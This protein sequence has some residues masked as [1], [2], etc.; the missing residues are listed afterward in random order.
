M[1]ISLNTG[2]RN[3]TLG[4]QET[5]WETRLRTTETSG[6]GFPRLALPP[7]TAEASL[8][9]VVYMRDASGQT[10]MYVDGVEMGRTTIGGTLTNWD[11][12]YR[13]GLANELNQARPW[14]GELHLVA[15]YDRALSSA[16][17]VQNFDA[18]SGE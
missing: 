18:G 10:L 6:N 13:L 2:A 14:L 4:Q 17:V 16:E 8:Q 9:H 15:F 11:P 3:I 1:T 5:G 12:G 7:G